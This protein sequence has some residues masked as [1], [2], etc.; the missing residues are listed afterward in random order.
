MLAGAFVFGGFGRPFSF[1]CDKLGTHAV[2][3]GDMKLLRQLQCL[4]RHLRS[5]KFGA[6]PAPA[7]A[8]EA[9]YDFPLAGDVTLTFGNALLGLLDGSDCHFAFA[10]H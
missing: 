8:F 10:D 7:F 5:P 2:P 1:A 9:D 4:R 6:T 3:L